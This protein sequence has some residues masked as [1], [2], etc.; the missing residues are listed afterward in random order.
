MTNRLLGGTPAWPCPKCAG[1]L[2]VVDSR[3]STF[4]NAAT[5]RRRRACD[6]CGYRFTTFEITAD[7]MTAQVEQIAAAADSSV[8]TLTELLR[9]LRIL[10]NG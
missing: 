3:P 9:K 2:Q 5:V 10:T 4:G 1:Q 7:A 6:V 8:V